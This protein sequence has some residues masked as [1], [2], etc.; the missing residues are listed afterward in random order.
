MKSLFHAPM[1]VLLSNGTHTAPDLGK[2][3]PR[4]GAE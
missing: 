1:T 3:I 4:G 2:K